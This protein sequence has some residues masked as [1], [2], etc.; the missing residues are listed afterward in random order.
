[1]NDKKKNLSVHFNAIQHSPV[2][3]FYVVCVQVAGVF[4]RLYFVVVYWVTHQ[5]VSK[6]LAYE[7][8]E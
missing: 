4:L 6:I 1:M 7:R 2:I 3:Y 8:G 5:E